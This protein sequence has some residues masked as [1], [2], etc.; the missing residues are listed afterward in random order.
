M[1]F[2][3]PRNSIDGHLAV[4]DR[5]DCEL[6]IAPAQKIPQID[7]IMEKRPMKQACL[8]E[9]LEL[10]DEEPA[11]EYTYNVT[12]AEARQD[13]LVVLHTSGSTGLP[14]PIIVPHGS[15]ATTD[16]HHLL[17]PIETRLTVTQLFENPYRV[18]STFPL[19]HVRCSFPK[20]IF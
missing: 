20:P 13:P 16:A 14:K 19:F 8:P 9:L 12:F 6:W 11:A 7:Q 17:P 10:L 15:L 2:L 4:I 1:M 5:C 3:S 18:Y